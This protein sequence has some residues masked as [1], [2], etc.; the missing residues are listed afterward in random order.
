M[1]WL[2][3]SPR[4]TRGYTDYFFA[5]GAPEEDAR[6]LMAFSRQVGEEDLALVESVQR[7]LDSGM[8]PHGRL[9]ED[10]EHLIQHFQ[11]LLYDAIA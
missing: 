6:E 1:T 2:P 11:R 4:H 3:S 5:P 10:S 8:V 9:L 7:G